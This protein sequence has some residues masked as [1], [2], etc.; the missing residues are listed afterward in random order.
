MDSDNNLEFIGEDQINHTGRNE[1]VR[2]NTGKA[3]DLV[4]KTMV[5][6]QKQISQRVSERTVQITLRNNSLENKSIGVLYQI[7]PNSK[8]VSSEKPYDM[9]QNRKVTF[10]VDIQPDKEFVF[11][12]VERSNAH[13]AR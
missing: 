13:K 7:D 4:G 11:S 3:F 5:L 2:I 10:I 1:T 6:T 8:I 12:F 9:D